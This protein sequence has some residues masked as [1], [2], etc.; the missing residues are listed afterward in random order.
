M[1]R[2]DILLGIWGTLM[3]VLVLI[4]LFD[5]AFVVEGSSFILSGCLPW[6]VC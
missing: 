6:A 5:L 3:T 2:I 4:W 1:K